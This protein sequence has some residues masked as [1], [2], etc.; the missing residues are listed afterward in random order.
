MEIPLMTAFFLT[1]FF[2]FRFV[3]ILPLALQFISTGM[4]LE[5]GQ[6]ADSSQWNNRIKHEE[7]S[8]VERSKELQARS[9]AIAADIRRLKKRLTRVPPPEK[10]EALHKRLQEIV[11]QN[12]WVP[13]LQMVFGIRNVEPMIAKDE[14]LPENFVECI[15]QLKRD[16]EKRGVDL[17]YMPLAASPTIYGHELVEGIDAHHEY[18][19]GWTKMLLELLENDIEVIDPLEEF[20]AQSNADLIVNWPNDFHTGDGGRLIAAQM[21]ADRLQ[22]YEFAREWRQHIPEWEMERQTVASHASRI[23]V[24]N[25]RSGHAKTYPGAPKL[26]RG[27]RKFDII[28]SVKPPKTGQDLRKTEVV[29]IGDSQLHSAVYG[30][31]WPAIAMGQIRAQVRW[32]SRSGSMSHDLAP[33]Y[34]QVVPDYA[35]QPRV[36]VVTTLNKY[37]LKDSVSAPRA[38]PERNATDS[39]GIPQTRFDCTIEFTALSERPTTDAASLDYDHAWFHHAAKIV[40]GPES[41]MGREIGVRIK[42]LHKGNWIEPAIEKPKVGEKFKVRLW[43]VETWKDNAGSKGTTK[44]I[45][46]QQLFDTVEQELTIPVFMMADWTFGWTY[47]PRK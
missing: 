47:V 26:L 18:H 25:K 43:Y 20:R 39:H 28:Q 41:M 42:C 3:L 1:H 38:M 13:E 33:I 36:V 37:F 11:A 45:L 15:V 14:T 2:R 5:G 7:P 10:M 17:I 6:T 32:G 4:A 30:A 29:L 44:R 34:M 31:G 24:V 22:R 9:D 46:Q 19:P 21:L 8:E 40:E 16:L 27:K 35:Q 12:G 23:S